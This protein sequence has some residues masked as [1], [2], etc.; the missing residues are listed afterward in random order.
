MERALLV[1]ATRGVVQLFNAVSRAKTAREEAAAAGGEAK[2][3][4]ALPR[5]FLAELRRAAAGGAPGGGEK[6]PGWDV[7]GDDFARGG[8]GGRL[9]A[10]ERGGRGE[11]AQLEGAGDEE[12]ALADEFDDI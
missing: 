4:K 9:R 7:L 2:A 1:T 11:A 8:D 3:E 5:A 12:D 10:W 6:K